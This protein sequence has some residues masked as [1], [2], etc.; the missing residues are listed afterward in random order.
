M[1]PTNDVGTCHFGNGQKL[2][3]TGQR[4]SGEESQNRFAS[5]SLEI[6]E[7][8]VYGRIIGK[9]YNSTRR[10]L[11]DDCQAT[12]EILNRVEIVPNSWNTLMQWARCDRRQQAQGE[13]CTP[14][15]K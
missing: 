12:N 5:V 15:R 9:L 11:T 7:R 1:E 8:E 3:G 4:G 10:D 13:F 2:S 6:I 14:I